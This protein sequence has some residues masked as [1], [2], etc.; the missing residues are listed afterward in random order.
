MDASSPQGPYDGSTIRALA[1]SNSPE[2]LP[3]RVVVTRNLCDGSTVT[4]SPNL[5]PIA[6]RRNLL[7]L[8]AEDTADDVLIAQ[9]GPDRR[10]DLASAVR[11]ADVRRAHAELDRL[12]ATRVAVAPVP[13]LALKGS[14]ADVRQ[15]RGGGRRGRRQV[16]RAASRGGDSGDD[17]PGE[18]PPGRGGAPRHVSFALAAFLEE[19]GS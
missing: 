6:H 1:A 4:L 8:I 19:L 15:T 14:R 9:E 10:P 5:R 3:A 11:S 13:P 16:S 12:T 7:H 18:P 17:G 2:K